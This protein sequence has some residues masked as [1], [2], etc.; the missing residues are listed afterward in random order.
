MINAPSVGAKP[1]P[2]KVRSRIERSMNE[3]KARNNS[4]LQ[5]ART[6][7]I[8]TM[9]AALVFA[10]LFSACATTGPSSTVA[11]RAQDRWDALLAGDFEN[12]YQYYSP[13][14]RSSTS[15]GDFEVGMRLR[16]VQYSGATYAGENCEEDRCV[17]KFNVQYQVA[18]PVPGLDKWE[19]KTMLDETWVRTQG[20]WW[21]VPDTN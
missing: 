4:E 20:Q 18:S 13:G 15:R 3:N 21:Y 12:A 9:A 6:A 17:L 11:K 7:T 5:Q 10:F 8:R 2:S 1:T 16:K 14:F 19:S